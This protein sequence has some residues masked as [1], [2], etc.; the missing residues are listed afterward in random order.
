[1]RLKDGGFKPRAY[2][3]AKACSETIKM[4]RPY[5]PHIAFVFLCVSIYGIF[6]CEKVIFAKPSLGDKVNFVLLC[7]LFYAMVLVNYPSWIRDSEGDSLARS[8]IL[9]KKQVLGTWYLVLGAGCLVLGAGFY[10]PLLFLSSLWQV[11]TA[12][13]IFIRKSPQIWGDFHASL[14]AERGQNKI[15]PWQL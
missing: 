14:W 7:F 4:H 11:F 13:G 3:A 15:C 6:A 9:Y 5:A 2:S 1:M 10:Q 8:W 12:M